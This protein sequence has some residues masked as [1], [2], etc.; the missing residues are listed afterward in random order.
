[1]ILKDQKALGEGLR[2]KRPRVRSGQR[3]LNNLVDRLEM[4]DTLRELRARLVGIRSQGIVLARLGDE[5][6]LWMVK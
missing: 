1:M 4:S 5:K 3:G 6:V 2:I